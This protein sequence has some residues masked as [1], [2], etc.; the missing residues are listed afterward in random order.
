[1]NQE[2][3]IAAHTAGEGNGTMKTSTGIG[4]VRATALGAILLSLAGLSGCHRDPNKQKQKYL[5][6]G[7]RY[8]AE[9][10]Y[11]EA[12]IQFS[13]ALKVDHNFAE[14][15]MELGTA[16]L[17]MGSVMP[18]YSE[19]NR[20]V[21][22]QP[23]NVKARIEL[24]DL[25]LAGK[26]PDRAEEQAKAILA[27]KPDNADAYALLSSIAATRNNKAE[28]LAQIQHALELDPNRAAFH[29][30]LGLIQG[31]D[32]KDSPEAEEQLRKAVALDTHNA[33]AHLA[34]AALLERKGDLASAIEQDKAAVAADPKS[35]LARSSLSEIYNRQGDKT[36]AEATL[37]Q[38]AEDLSDVP[39]GA[40]LLQNYYLRSAQI[41]RGAQV[42]G[43]L[44]QKH[45]KSIPLKLTYARFLLA[46]HDISAARGVIADLEKSDSS[47]PDV[48]VLNGMMLLSD[49]KT[50]EAFDAVQKASKS[51]PDSAQ[52]HLWTGRAAMRKGDLAT[53]QQSFADAAKLSPGNVD[54]RDGLA[55]VAMQ[56]HDTNL[57]A[58]VAEAGIAA[59]PQ[60][61]VGY[62]WRGMAEGGQQPEKA[63][64]DF[65]QALKLDPKNW[66]AMLELAQ[67]KLSQNK[68]S[69]AR[70]LLEEAMSVNPNSSRATGMMASTYLTE[71]QPQKALTVLQTQIA[72]APQNAEMYVQLSEIQM[73]TGDSNGALA[74]AQKAT[75]L[76]PLNEQAVVA[77][78]RAELAKGDSPK[79]IDS[80]Q[81]WLK[82]HPG[83]AQGFANLGTLQQGQGEKEKAIDSYKKALSIQPEQPVAANN[84]AYLMID[85]GQNA[86]VA[87]SYAQTARRILPNSPSTADTL[88]WVYYAKGTYS[89]ARDL[90]EEAAKQAPDDASIQYHLGMTYRKLADSPNAELHLKKA[91]SLAPDSQTG[92][93]AQRALTQ[94][95]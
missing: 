62:V 73:L 8:A 95:S 76:N 31:S 65:H 90:L 16:Y 24:G 61:A 80:W 43:E 59:S 30:A 55:Q 70:S 20:A 52:L 35:L 83:D 74:S 78:T 6:S 94:Q 47:D 2:I 1:M 22:L 19:L 27:M 93:D 36:N 13:N 51:N 91:V 15:H 72:K 54:A 39:G 88:A 9:G 56:K 64:A 86:D 14:A 29:T 57:L 63:E 69:E 68:A 10:K 26:L 84:L 67:L 17:K 66:G 5:E 82:T 28:A 33:T 46:K 71:K 77:L 42:Y 37:R 44:S 53:A 79:A 60:N 45:P 48:A 85:G 92:K 18:G 89:S 25:L 3:T 38:A 41:D 11:K 81:N 50:N 4:Y 49:N 87:L 12:A 23:G 40:Q 7:K 75:Q 58:Q 21:A 34:L 32:P